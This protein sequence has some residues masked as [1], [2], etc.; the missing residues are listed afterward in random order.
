MTVVSYSV[1]YEIKTNLNFDISIK[2]EDED[3][4]PS[5][6]EIGYSLTKNYRSYRSTFSDK[7]LVIE[8][9]KN[10]RA[11]NYNF[12][13]NDKEYEII[14]NTITGTWWDR[15]EELIFSVIQTDIKSE[16]TKTKMEI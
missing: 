15:T 5:L 12:I 8:I 16:T 13:Y 7:D 4:V 6:I 2:E 14:D 9:V 11:E 1:W 3:D 10:L